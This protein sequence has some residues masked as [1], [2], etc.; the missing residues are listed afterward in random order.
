M[1]NVYSVPFIYESKAKRKYLYRVFKRLA[2]VLI[3]S[4]LLLVSSPFWLG[5]WLYAVVFFSEIHLKKEMVLGKN[6]QL[7]FFPKQFCTTS[8][9]NSA[10]QYIWKNAGMDKIA[11]L[12]MVF[13]GDFSLFGPPPLSPLDR[14]ASR[15]YFASHFYAVKPGLLCFSSFAKEASQSAYSVD[16]L[17][18]LGAGFRCDW[19]LCQCI[20][21]H[22]KDKIK[23]SK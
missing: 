15:R 14:D 8:K 1:T 20:V 18:A 12:W 16:M 17:Y 21:R 13:L 3:S 7:I 6:N 4:F 23:S 19:M 2:D 5:F 22:L 10:L 11:K 9:E